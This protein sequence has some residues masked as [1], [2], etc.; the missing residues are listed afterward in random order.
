ME[1]RDTIVATVGI[2]GEGEGERWYIGKRRSGPLIR[3]EGVD[4]GHVM[5]GVFGGLVRGTAPV[6]IWMVE[7]EQLWILGDTWR[8]DRGF[9]PF[10]LAG[11]LE[12]GLRVAPCPQSDDDTTTRVR[13]YCGVSFHTLSFTKNVYRCIFFHFKIYEHNV[14][15][16]I[17]F[18]FMRSPSKNIN[19]NLK[20]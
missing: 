8:G 6:M 19:S 20:P 4:G 11:L 18:Y 10:G 14:P 17:H 12:R 5:A 3:G 13:Q 7:G 1:Y 15:Q 9:R 2:K 16:Q